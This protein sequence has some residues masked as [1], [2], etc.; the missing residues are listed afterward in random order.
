MSYIEVKNSYKRYQMGDTEIVANNNV[1]FEVNEGE[2]AII[3]G[4]SGAGKSTMLNV[5]GG[6]D[7]ND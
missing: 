4:A 3:L 6:M 2:L 1:S 5:L 7:V